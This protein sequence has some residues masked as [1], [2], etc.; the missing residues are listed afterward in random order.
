[1]TTCPH[2]TTHDLEHGGFLC[3]PC[4]RATSRR[5]RALPWLWAGLEAR[6]MPG[7]STPHAMGRTP[8]AT[9][10]LP[11][12]E[13]VLDLR[14]EGGIVTVLETWRLLVHDARTLP[15]PAPAV[16]IGPRVT[17]AATALELHLDWIARWH[18]APDLARDVNTLVG[19]SLAVIQLGH[20]TDQARYLGRCIAQ[21]TDGTVCGRPLYAHRERVV[22]CEWCLCRYTPDTWLALRHHQPGR[23]AA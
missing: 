9:A 19:R 20:D 8:S 23:R 10:A 2:C 18:R 4:I 16:G 13:E 3:D 14:A 6:L 5:L 22:Q 7:S 15:P 11:L 21:S 12:Q 17:I 1:M